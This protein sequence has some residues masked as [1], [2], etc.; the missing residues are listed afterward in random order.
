[1]PS[2]YTESMIELA[3]GDRLYLYSDGIPEATKADE[4]QFG[5]ERLGELLTDLLSEDV[6]SLYF[7]F[8][9]LSI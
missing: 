6:M 4:E 9:K 2:E 1:M 7:W 5:E 8:I 3:P